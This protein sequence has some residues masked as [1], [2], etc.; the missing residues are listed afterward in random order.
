[1][2]NLEQYLLSNKI[3]YSRI[4]ADFIQIE[5]LKY[6]FV[7]PDIEGMLFSIDFML[8][9]DE[10]CDRYIYFFGGNWYWDEKKDS[11]KP[12]LNELKY[13]GKS[14]SDIETDSFLGIRG[15]YEILNGS[16]LYEDWCKKAKF[17]G[18]KS[19]GICEKN[20][21]AGILK[22]QIECSKN[23]IQS[24][25]GATYTVFR[26]KDDFRYDI[27]VY[28]KDELGWE[29]LL[30]INKEVNVVNHKFI[31]EDRLLELLE[32]LFTVVDP[33]SLDFDKI[34]KL[35][36]HIDFYQLDTVEY[37]NDSRDKY[38]LENLRNYVRSDLKPISIT[39]AFY[40]DSEHSHIKK[41]LN[42]ISS[43]REY[44]SKNQYFKDKEDYYNE[45]EKLFNKEDDSLFDLFE[46]SLSNEKYIVDNCNFKVEIGK[47][48]LP[49]YI[50]T[51]EQ[52]TQFKDKEDL[53]WHLIGKGM[54]AKVDEDKREE[55]LDRVELEYSV[56]IKGEKLIDYFLILWDII[57]WCDKKD[58][59]VGIGRGSAGGCLVAYL[60]DI[61]NIDPLE[62]NLLFERFLNENRVNKSLPDVDSDFE[63][64][65]RDEVKGYM[66]QR[67]G[68]EVKIMTSI[69]GDGEKD[70]TDWNEIFYLSTNSDKL[71]SFVKKYPD[72]I[73]DARL[74]LMQPRSSSIHAC[75]TIVTPISKDIFKWF[76]VKKEHNKGGEEILVS[77]WEGIQLDSAGFLKE[78]ILGILQLD[79]IANTIK[80]IYENTGIKI[81]FRN[82]PTDDRKTYKYFHMGWNEDV[83]QFGTK[84]LKNYTRELK[85]DN[86]D[87]LSAAN[88]LYRP[89]AMKSNAHN[90]YILIKFG[91]KN[92]EYDYMLK[93]VTKDTYGL[94]IY[95]EQTMLASQKI[96][97]FTLIEADVLRKV[98]LKKGKKGDAS[99]NE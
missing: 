56:I 59:L 69:L 17:L 28:A 33:K 99:R 88:A 39:D 79:K 34:G 18:C 72:I 14:T 50:L 83:F 97:G 92:V 75:A 74:C 84:G 10:T 52:K 7:R 35:K 91:K 87:D 41:I 31:I 13:I 47:F 64:L 85:P 38:Y 60:L 43:V 40:L 36:K 78:D 61:T 46:Q 19:L 89:G 53:F 42:A 76:P 95:Q 68:K 5:G 67:F 66:E 30:M 21:L 25:I 45:L 51:D 29:N 15:A 55:Y 63:G 65:R 96:A 94:Y 70:G 32:G 16:R 82:I 37:V 49:D 62:Y 4:D 6:F 22:F 71:K 2:I 58:I 98:I 12:K 73:N 90:D 77:E 1:M 54:D 27:K 3:K 44:E 24:I 93:E 57:D 26:D 23:E 48:H 80:L 8:M 81:D 86:I 20:T 11:E 9:A